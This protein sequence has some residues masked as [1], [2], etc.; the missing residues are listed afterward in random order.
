MLNDQT[1]YCD[2]TAP[3]RFLGDLNDLA[4]QENSKLKAFVMYLN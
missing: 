2:H 3:Q 4:L 1:L